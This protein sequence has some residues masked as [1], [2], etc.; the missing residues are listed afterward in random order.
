MADHYKNKK[1]Q[2][3]VHIKVFFYS[4]AIIINELTV[5]NT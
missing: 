2:E 1:K 3:P 5:K 4:P